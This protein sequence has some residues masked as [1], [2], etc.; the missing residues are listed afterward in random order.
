MHSSTNPNAALIDGDGLKPRSRSMSRKKCLCWFLGVPALVIFV[1]YFSYYQVQC[2]AC[3]KVGDG[4][5]QK[6]EVRMY[7]SLPLNPDLYLGDNTLHF[8]NSTTKLSD[9]I[10]AVYTLDGATRGSSLR[11]PSPSPANSSHSRRTFDSRPGRRY[12]DR[13]RR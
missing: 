1:V 13:A 12:H 6:K 9:V 4:G 3:K 7:N 8:M 11:H 5:S 10:G 2:A